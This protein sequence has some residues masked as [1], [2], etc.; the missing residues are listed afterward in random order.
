MSAATGNTV[1]YASASMGRKL[2]GLALVANESFSPRDDL[3]RAR[4]VFVRPEHKLLGQSYVGRVLVLDTAVGGLASAWTLQ[5]MTALG[6][7]PAALVLNAVSAIM[8]QGA[9]LADFTMISGFNCDITGAIPSG[10]VVE[11]DPTGARPF[12]RIIDT[13][14]MAPR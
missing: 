2:T 11:V 4:G 5:E 10:A 14:T 13:N 12:I 8:V 6:M 3:D 9:A 7:R 1:F